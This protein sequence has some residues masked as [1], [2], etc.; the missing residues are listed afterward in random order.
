MNSASVQT[1]VV[2]CERN[3]VEMTLAEALCSIILYNDSHLFLLHF[4]VLNCRRILA[5]LISPPTKD[6]H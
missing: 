3:S 6:I 2:I 1:T 5:V 4:V